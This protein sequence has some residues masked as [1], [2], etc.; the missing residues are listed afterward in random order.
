MIS[1]VVFKD[2]A[3]ADA[4]RAMQSKEVSAL[5]LVAPPTEKH[6]SFVRRL[7]REDVNSF[8]IVIPVDSA[9]AIAD[10][11][12]PYESFDIPKGTLRGAPA[13]SR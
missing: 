6:L 5:L 12:G 10:A 3:P 9:G 4:R 8:P 11:T 2:V 1:N 7:F 13:G